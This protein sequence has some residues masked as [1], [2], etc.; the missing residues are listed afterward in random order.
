MRFERPN[1]FRFNAERAVQAA[2]VVL[3]QEPSHSMNYMKLL[4]VLYMAERK[5]LSRA[6]SMITGDRFVAMERGPVLSGVYDLIKG[7]HTD[8]EL[9][10]TFIEKERYNVRLKSP[11]G[12]DKLSKLEI[13]ILSDV[14]L[15]YEHFDEWDMV[16]ETHK[17]PEWKKNQPEESSQNPIPLLHVLEA[18]GLNE[19]T[20]EIIEEARKRAAFDDFFARN[21]TC[22]AATPSSSKKPA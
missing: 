10:D 1:P 22:G 16:R 18:I 4:K 13:E 15:E 12:V 14:A 3:R 7:E 5:M 2:A 6:G 17:L 11:P 19:I 8:S 21:G 20:G 9:W